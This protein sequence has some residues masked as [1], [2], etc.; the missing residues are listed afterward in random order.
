MYEPQV[1]EFVRFDGGLTD[2]IISGPENAY[3]EA[4]N[5]LI[6][7]D[8]KLLSRPGIQ[9]YLGN[10][11]R[12]AQ[13]ANGG[14]VSF[15]DN[16]DQIFA[17]SRQSLYQ[18]G[19][20]PTLVEENGYNDGVSFITQRH[21]ANDP[22][23]TNFSRFVYQEQIITTDDTYS[24][25]R[26][27]Y[28]ASGTYKV[29]AYGLPSV[30]TGSITI[31]DNGGGGSA[32]Y[33]FVY[34]REY[35]HNTLTFVE[36]GSTTAV[37]VSNWQ[38]PSG[39]NPVTFTIPDLIND[40]NSG[41]DQY[42]RDN[43]KLEIYRTVVVGSDP[44]S[45]RIG[46]VTLPTTSGATTVFNDTFTDAEITGNL[47]LYTDSGE[48]ENGAPPQCKYVTFAN[49]TAW[50]AN[51]QEGS[52]IRPNVVKHSLP[53][54]PSAVPGSYEVEFDNE[55]TGISAINVYA[56]VF[57]RDSIFRLEGTVDSL[58][59][60]TIRKREISRTIGCISNAS[61][62]QTRDALMFAA[63]DGFYWTDGFKIR[64]ISEEFNDRYATLVTTRAKELDIKGAFDALNHR[65]E[66]TAQLDRGVIDNGDKV[67]FVCDL[68]HT[69]PAGAPP[70]TTWSGGND[71]SNF[72][73]QAIYS[74]GKTTLFGDDRGYIFQLDDTT[75]TD[76]IIDESEADT[77]LWNQRAIIYNYQSCSLDYG[78]KHRRKIATKIV[79]S[80]ENRTNLSMAVLSENDNSGIKQALQPIK[81]GG[82]LV[83]GDEL[84]FWGDLSV[85]WNFTANIDQRRRFPKRG[86]RYNYKAIQL[87][88]NLDILQTSDTLGTVTTNT[89]TNSVSLD[90]TVDNRWITDP[91]DYFISFDDENHTNLYK[92]ISRTDDTTVIC[93]DPD[94]RFV[95]GANRSFRL[96]GFRKGE[97]LNLIAYTIQY[98]LMTASQEPF[99][100]G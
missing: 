12:V 53:L 3:E 89:A 38:E 11:P 13:E 29:A 34:R 39:G 15:I 5:F 68:N 74:R 42:D 92:I 32:V 30:D 86:L 98:G 70:F 36:R 78:T 95:S 20:T 66:W 22:E 96:S 49:N 100:A 73:P 99:R 55:I 60:G 64:K 2:N 33:T 45:Y 84:A 52:A 16:S 7:Y 80:A 1:A 62:V 54:K 14:V 50:Y 25:P 71:Q 77:S 31:G 81:F 85:R 28:D 56:I 72:R 47:Q 37:S 67:L 79:V 26:Q 4:D 75:T 57:T 9:V 82:K 87:T 69:S 24:R 58:G 63:E 19:P 59:L 27:I 94:G 21:F 17:T 44:F 48:Q 43:T 88:N 6:S 46:L 65:V 51:I 97:V 10:Y 18:V 90:I 83:W 93:E 40:L 61:I 23:T 8:F 76:V 91:V 35:T 41:D